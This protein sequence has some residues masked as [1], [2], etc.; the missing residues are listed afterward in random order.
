MNKTILLTGGLG[1]CVAL[2]EIIDTF[3]QTVGI[4]KMV[5][6]HAG[7]KRNAISG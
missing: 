2:S 1:G 7:C 4:E 5:R 6:L 3:V